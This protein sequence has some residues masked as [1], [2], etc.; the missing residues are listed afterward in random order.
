M[1]KIGIVLRYSNLKDGR[2]ILYLGDMIR[3]TIQKA[4][5]FIIPI[6]QV[7]DVNYNSTRWNEFDELLEDE[8]EIVEEYLNMVDGVIFPGGFKLTPYDKYVLN[9]CVELDKRVLGICLGMQLLCSYDRNFKVEKNN[10]NINHYQDND[11][12]LT[13]RIKIK[14]NTKLYEILKKE[15]I[16]VNSF[17]NYHVAEPTE[18]LVIN[19]T[20]ED[21][22]VE[23]VELKDKT[24]IMGIQWHPEISYDFD[25]NSKKI[26]DY[27]IKVCGK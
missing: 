10:S 27:F 24:F 2:D 19:A 7:Q 22:N 8:K 25:E 18:G 21:N 9:R 6:V 23:G 12:D 11:D 4:G 3:R 1:K 13:H 20:S 16:E 26:I 15:E 14:K 17:H 5:G